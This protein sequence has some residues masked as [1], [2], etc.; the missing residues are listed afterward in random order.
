MRHKFAILTSIAG[1]LLIPLLAARSMQAASYIWDGD[2]S[3]PGDQD[4]NGTWTDTGNN[5]WDPNANANANWA[6]ADPDSATFGTGDGDTTAYTVTLSGGITTGGITFANTNYTIAGTDTLTITRAKHG[7]HH[8][9]Q[10]SLRH[11]FLPRC[12]WGEPNLDDRRQRDAHRLQRRFRGAILDQGRPGNGYFDGGQ[13]LL[14]RHDRRQRHTAGGAG[15]TTGT[16]PTGTAGSIQINSTG[17]LEYYRTNG[18]STFTINNA[19]VGGGTLYLKGIITAANSST[20]NSMFTASAMNSLFTG[21]II[22]DHAR[23]SS[24]SSAANFGGTSAFQILDTGQ[25]YLAGATVSV[26]ISITG[27]GWYDNPTTQYR[28]APPG[29]RDLVRSHHARRK[30]PNRVGQRHGDNQGPD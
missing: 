7:R 6:N 5:W 9:Q 15:S 28:G 12:P 10:R 13:H 4:G 8:R 30:R 19:Y 27:N 26:P 11:H 3:T 21:T 17:T 24:A 18:T 14:R 29:Y 23:I 22:A 20:H 16:I 25:I 2:T 1:L